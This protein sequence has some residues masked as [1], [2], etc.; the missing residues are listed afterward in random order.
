MSLQE[1]R[2]RDFGSWGWF[3]RHANARKWVSATLKGLPTLNE[4]WIFVDRARYFV[5]WLNSESLKFGGRFVDTLPNSIECVQ[6]SSTIF[7]M[8][9]DWPVQAPWGICL[10]PRSGLGR[11]KSRKGQ[12][13]WDRKLTCFGMGWKVPR[14]RCSVRI[15]VEVVNTISNYLINQL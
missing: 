10:L 14:L 13:Y 6:L 12:F 7:C 5:A 2:W 15:P 4:F 1:G 9:M 11:G 3:V 8:S